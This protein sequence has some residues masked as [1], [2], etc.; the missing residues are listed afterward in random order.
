MINWL[1][2]FLTKLLDLK[3]EKMQTAIIKISLTIGISLQLLGWLVFLII[4]HFLK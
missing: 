1:F 2:V 4:K 3:S